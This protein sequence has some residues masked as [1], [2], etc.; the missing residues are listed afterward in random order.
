LAAQ[1]YKVAAFTENFVIH[2]VDGGFPGGRS[3]VDEL[4]SR[5]GKLQMELGVYPEGKAEIFIVPDRASYQ[6]LARGRG[7]IVEFSE[8]FYSG[9]ERRIYARS[10]DQVPANYSGLILHEY[11]H[12]LLDELMIGAPLWLHE[13]LATEY[14][15]QLGLDRYYHYVRERFWGNRMDLFRLAYN[16]PKQREDW[17][18]YYL[19][20]YFAVRYMREK[21]PKAWRAFWNIVAA[22]NRRG[23]RVRFA[24]AFGRAYN[25]NLHSFSLDFAE[26]S[27]RK[28]WIYL[29]TGFSSLIFAL[30]PFMVIIATLRQRRKMKA[31]PDLELPAEIEVTVPETDPPEAS[32]QD[33]QPEP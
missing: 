8:A 28:A 23:E 20:S 21:D 3:F 22:H 5:I 14:G 33:E 12:W 31:L 10:A 25:S 11:T 1:E 9:R 32:G 17:E 7:A 2:S 4:D 6:A 27:R 30:L 15:H 18:M 13:G 19:T 26:A 16:Y 29:I 24:E